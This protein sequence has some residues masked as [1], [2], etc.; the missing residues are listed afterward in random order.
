MS[1]LG[2]GPG[3]LGALSLDLEA[4][5]YLRGSYLPRGGVPAEVGERSLEP[6]VDL[7]QSQLFV[8]GFHDR[9][10]ATQ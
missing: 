5:L 2:S 1:G 8:R 9:L 3:S 7:V 10:R 4:S 6:A